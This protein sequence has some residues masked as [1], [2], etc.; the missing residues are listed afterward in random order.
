MP[1]IDGFAVVERL[2]AD[3]ATADIPIV[4]LTAKDMTAEDQSALNGQI[5]HLARKGEFDRAE[6]L[7]LVDAVTA[8]L[9]RVSGRGAWPTSPD[10]DRRGQREEPEAGR[11]TCCSS[12]GYRT[13]E[14]TTAEDGI[15]L[16]REH[17]PDLILMD[18]QLPGMDGVAALGRL[19]ADPAT[20]ASR[21]SR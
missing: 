6:L 18:I 7:A 14:A 17:Q 8:R 4:V 15:E 5:S 3:P 9:G 20:A 11:A 10:P 12:R 1:D 2:R 16:A 13:L 19:R 21:S